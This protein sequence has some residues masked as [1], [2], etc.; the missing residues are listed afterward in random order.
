MVPDALTITTSHVALLVA[1]GLLLIGLALGL[2][3]C[4]VGPDMEDR[5]TALLLL[6]TGG[7]AMLLLLGVLLN[8]DAL[9]DVALV[10]ALLAVVMTVAVTRKETN[11]D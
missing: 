5:F 2:I 3:R 1:L 7:A 10:L 11:D 6:G 9:Y 4:Y 8:M